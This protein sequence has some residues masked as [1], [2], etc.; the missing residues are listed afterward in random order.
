MS[1]PNDF[2][3]SVLDD[4]TICREQQYLQL[5]INGG[6]RLYPPEQHPKA[7]PTRNVNGRQVCANVRVL[8]K[9][10]S[11]YSQ[12]WFAD[13][14]EE[15]SCPLVDFVYDCA[16]VCKDGEKACFV[17]E[18]WHYFVDL[19]D[20]NVCAGCG[21]HNNIPGH[22]F[23]SCS[24]CKIVHYCSKAC[25]HS[26]WHCHKNFCIGWKG[27]RVLPDS[28]CWMGPTAG[29][30]KF[31][32][33]DEANEFFAQKQKP[34]KMWT[35]LSQI[36]RATNDLLLDLFTSPS[37]KDAINLY[38]ARH[39]DSD[40]PTLYTT[41][42]QHPELSNRSLLK[43]QLEQVC[44]DEHN[45]GT[46][47]SPLKVA[48]NEHGLCGTVFILL[49]TMPGP[50]QIIVCKRS[51]LLDGV[52]QNR[53]WNKRKANEKRRQDESAEQYNM[54]RRKLCDNVM[55]W[56]ELV[57]RL[58]SPEVEHGTERE[59]I[60]FA[61][62]T[63]KFPL[64]FFNLNADRLMPYGL[65]GHNTEL[66]RYDLRK[67]RLSDWQVMLDE[68]RDFQIKNGLDFVGELEEQE[69]Q[70]AGAPVGTP[71]CQEQ[72]VALEKFMS[73]EQIVASEETINSKE[74]NEIRI[75]KPNRDPD[76]VGELEEQ[77]A[78][79]RDFINSSNAAIDEFM[80]SL[81]DVPTETDMSCITPTPPNS[82]V[83]KM[84]PPVSKLRRID[85]W[86][87]IFEEDE[88]DDVDGRGVRNQKAQHDDVFVFQG[89]PC[90]N[91]VAKRKTKSKVNKK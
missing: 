76:Y 71:F 33:I 53:D 50:F 38:P 44:Q 6:C 78:G 84:P 72:T 16:E 45:P 15:D 22:K 28:T 47:N 52:T 25:L 29:K 57:K 61:F 21:K 66:T 67:P 23:L 34:L 62:A 55:Y 14:P 64:M 68:M 26:N 81:K 17:V 51:T 12:L 8:P 48:M 3:M 80:K 87:S 49:R 36:K 73:Q 86:N 63:E 30:I 7:I 35:K 69:E 18:K 4:L 1:V 11:L 9:R 59:V 43:R 70:E 90:E 83:S 40:Y 27:R 82:P 20:M 5:R 13:R 89:R 2:E 37:E 60:M 39:V 56:H 24:K 85:E 42:S 32:N 54:R 91:A 77:Q 58:E 75:L 31:A 46:A 19:L 10:R 65:F 79:A 74:E 88:E 41:S